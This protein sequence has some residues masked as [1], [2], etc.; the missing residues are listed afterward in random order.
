MARMITVD[1]DYVMSK[2]KLSA[3]KDIEDLVAQAVAVNIP[4]NNPITGFC[5]FTHKA[6]IHAKAILN[7]PST[8]E[9]INPADFGLSRYVHFTSRLTGWNA[10]K[11]RAM[12]LNIDMSDEEFKQCTTK[13]KA[14][15]DI[16]QLAVDDV[17]SVIR[18]FHRSIT[19]GV[20]VPLLQDLTAEEEKKFLQK[21]RE[22]RQEPERR[23]LDQVVDEQVETGK[24][25]E[26][27]KANGITAGA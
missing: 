21:E 20:D 19:Q 7:N 9:I 27:A 22:M 16:R 11:S 10:I 23:E 2:Y 8:Y 3:L 13:V 15:A 26:K 18:A 25:V 17:D 5:A 4:F 14:M 6:G 24:V 1:R 12:Q